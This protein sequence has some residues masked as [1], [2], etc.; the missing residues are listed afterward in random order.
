M[1]QKINPD[2]NKKINDIIEGNYEISILGT[3]GKEN[4]PF[5]SKVLPMYKNNNLYIL[6]SDL[7]EHTKN[8]MLNKKV[9]F[10]FSLKET[11]K[12]KLNNPRLT[13]NGTVSKLNISKDDIKYQSLLESYNEI[14]KGSKMWGMFSDFNF[15]IFK[16][17]RALYIE[18]FG[19]AYEKK[20]PN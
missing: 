15:Y 18:G 17:K 13:L 1:Y 16:P 12:T 4:Y 3:I 19:K 9:S 14:D 2:V 20:Y 7:S 11:N 8:I 6:I 5:L 10:Y